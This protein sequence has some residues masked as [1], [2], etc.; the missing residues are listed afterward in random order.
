MIS[1][2]LNNIESFSSGA[3]TPI[4]TGAVG[5][6]WGISTPTTFVAAIDK[7]YDLHPTNGLAIDL[8]SLFEMNPKV[9]LTF[10]IDSNNFT[11]TKE[12]F[13]ITKTNN[14]LN[15]IPNTILLKNDNFQSK[16]FILP[17][18]YY[19]NGETPNSKDLINLKIKFNSANNNQIGPIELTFEYDNQNLSVALAS[20]IKEYSTGGLNG[21]FQVL[22]VN[23]KSLESLLLKNED[24][25]QGEFLVLNKISLLNPVIKLNYKDPSNSV[26]YIFNA[27]FK[28][29][30]QNP[31]KTTISN[32]YIVITPK[33]AA[34]I[35]I[36]DYV[37]GESYGLIL[38]E[39]YDNN[40]TPMTGSNFITFDISDSYISIIPK[41]KNLIDGTNGLKNSEQ[42]IKTFKYHTEDSAGIFNLYLTIE[43][44]NVIRNLED[45]KLLIPNVTSKILKISNKEIGLK[46][47]I[48]LLG[49]I[50]NSY[51]PLPEELGTYGEIRGTLVNPI[52]DNIN[53]SNVEK[54]ELFSTDKTLVPGIIKVRFNFPYSYSL[55]S[56]LKLEED[57]PKYEEY[58]KVSP[59]VLNVTKNYAPVINLYDY[60]F[61]DDENYK[62]L[63]FI[64]SD[65][66]NDI[67][68]RKFSCGN[69][70]LK[71]S[72]FNGNI[73][74]EIITS[75]IK[76]KIKNKYTD[77]DNKDDYGNIIGYRE[78][79]ITI[80][81]SSINN[82]IDTSE[83]LIIVDQK[84]YLNP[85]EEQN[86]I[87]GFNFESI[88]MGGLDYEKLETK[89]IEI[90]KIEL[91][92]STNI[93]TEIRISGTGTSGDKVVIG[94]IKNG[95]IVNNRLQLGSWNLLFIENYLANGIDEI[96]ID[97]K[98]VLDIEY[99]N[100][101]NEIKNYIQ[102][103]YFYK[104]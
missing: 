56:T 49:L 54:P 70:V 11:F 92:P 94:I 33:D 12:Y 20:L 25:I 65:I 73:S 5:S 100:S 45:Y 103:L 28:L 75:I 58:F 32:I 59:I 74:D 29:R 63:E 77:D 41:T 6:G 48:N 88:A 17:V 89:E 104:L 36:K 51:F 24:L 69:F 81:K 66:L 23:S 4:N 22:T 86:V 38:D 95:E 2:F 53:I 34:F 90:L 85:L 15:I 14:I 31:P 16:D 96:P 46:K 30:D 44:K 40:W 91:N 7:E 84:F 27:T 68:L 55:T 98:I 101:N 62:Y 18:F 87:E 57:T 97:G 39:V 64:G 42:F 82:D 78:L 19:K 52:I 10:D 50:K 99:K 26:D 71:R 1:N 43:M 79:P 35:D 93:P 9:E 60:I 8:Y 80:I 3:F 83:D 21:T 76:V 37:V 72:V 102:N 13:K 67:A 47:P 61:T